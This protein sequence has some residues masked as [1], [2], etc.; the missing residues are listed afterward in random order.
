MRKKIMSLLLDA[1]L[2]ETEVIVYMSLLEKPVPSR[3]D[4]VANT[5]LERNRVYRAFEK[6][7]GLKMV[8]KTKI[9][10]E[11][12]DLSYFVSQLEL[13]H[14]R[15]GVLA[16]QIR[17]LSPFLRLHPEC[18]GDFEVISDREVIVEKYVM[19]SQIEYD[20]C[21]DFGDLENFASSLGGLESIIAFRKYRFGR[22]AVSKAIC[23]NNG[24]YTACMSRPDDLR[25]FKSEIDVA[26]IDFGMK[27]VVCSDDSDYVMYNMFS[28]FHNPVSVIVKS[29]VIAD[30]QRSQFDLFYKN[31][32]KFI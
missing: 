6:L 21:L 30:I 10:I 16:S 18:G 2:S 13:S 14:K 5:G 15:M 23:T 25:R 22:N 3:W 19:M 9:G 29:R 27:W 24:P 8:E 12:L 31:L 7:M 17:E 28:D 11:A 26:Q 20:T 4:I 32:A 1:G